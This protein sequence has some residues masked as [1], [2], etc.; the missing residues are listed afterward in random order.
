MA[1]LSG[2]AVGMA[3]G[4]IGL[5][6]LAAWLGLAHSCDPAQGSG[7]I[8]GQVTMAPGLADQVA[9]AG[10]PIDPLVVAA[11]PVRDTTLI[12]PQ[13]HRRSARLIALRV[14]DPLHRPG[15]RVECGADR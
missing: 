5:A 12:P 14:V 6:A 9:V 7:V 1:A 3:S 13:A 11:S 2:R 10:A 8:A 15:A 4:I